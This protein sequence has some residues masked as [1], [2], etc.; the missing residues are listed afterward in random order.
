MKNI[1]CVFSWNPFVFQQ[2]VVGTWIWQE[3]EKDTCERTDWIKLDT[4]GVGV[5]FAASFKPTLNNIHDLFVWKVE[6]LKSNLQSSLLQK[7]A[8]KLQL[9]NFFLYNGLFGMHEMKYGIDMLFINLICC[10]KCLRNSKKLQ[11][12]TKLNILQW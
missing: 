3:C 6:V 12:C 1:F 11:H 2:V 5:S 4:F 8:I 10:L 7:R 9:I